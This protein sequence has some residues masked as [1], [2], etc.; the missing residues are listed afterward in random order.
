MN[1][2]YIEI[3]ILQNGVN[4]LFSSTGF[5]YQ[6]K[7]MEVNHEIEKFVFFQALFLK[8]YIFEVVTFFSRRVLI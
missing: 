7:I 8:M 6:T 1:K 4:P 2:P 5:Y 3:S